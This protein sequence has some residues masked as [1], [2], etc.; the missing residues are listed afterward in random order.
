MK[1]KAIYETG[2]LKEKPYLRLAN[3]RESHIWDWPMK[4][5]YLRLAN[6]RKA[7][8][9]T[10]QWEGKWSHEQMKSA[11]ISQAL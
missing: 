7:I 3:E 4:K 2:Q 10:G 1:R 5:P 8:S 11:S 9:E 6:E